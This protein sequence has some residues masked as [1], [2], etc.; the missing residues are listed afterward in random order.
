MKSIKE[1]YIGAAIVAFIIVFGVLSA[2]A[3]QE[4]QAPAH[5]DRIP[6]A[7]RPEWF[8]SYRTYGDPVTGLGDAITT[9]DIDTNHLTRNADGSITAIVLTSYSKGFPSLAHSD[10]PANMV[11]HV[12]ITYHLKCGAQVQVEYESQVSYS[13]GWSRVGEGE[14]LPKGFNDIGYIGKDITLPLACDI[15]KGTA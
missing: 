15:A 5:G 4:G 2:I 14:D 13:A 1:L 11:Y 3:Y 9:K 6:A 7:E 10:S 12:I 8:E